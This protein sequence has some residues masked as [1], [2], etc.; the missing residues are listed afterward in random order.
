MRAE[1]DVY[2]C[3][4]WA[5][6]TGLRHVR[7]LL[8]CVSLSLGP[9]LSCNDNRPGKRWN[10]ASFRTLETEPLKLYMGIC[11]E[12]RLYPFVRKTWNATVHQIGRSGSRGIRIYGSVVPRGFLFP[13]CHGDYPKNVQGPPLTSLLVMQLMH[14]GRHQDFLPVSK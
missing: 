1:Y 6:P 3:G 11:C 4:N 13:P 5:K 8:C 2:V 12:R 10:T 9:S 7:K 14:I